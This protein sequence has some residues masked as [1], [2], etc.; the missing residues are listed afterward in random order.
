[1]QGGGAR[2]GDDTELR[3]LALWLKLQT[4]WVDEWLPHPALSFERVSE[5]ESLESH[6]ICTHAEIMWFLWSFLAGF[7]G[8][9]L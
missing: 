9:L 2:E 7:E 8:S 6:S 1:M 5:I 3:Q 4:L